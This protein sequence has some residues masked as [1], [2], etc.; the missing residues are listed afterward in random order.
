MLS[1]M[2]VHAVRDASAAMAAL[3]DFAAD[4][5]LTDVRMPGTSGVELLKI[6]TR[7]RADLSIVLLTG[8]GDVPMAVETLKAGAFDFLTKPH[9]PERLVTV[10]RNAAEQSRLKSRIRHLE[11]DCNHVSS[12]E[13]ALIGNAPEMERLRSNILDLA[14]LPVDVLLLGET[15]TGKE[16]AARA[17]HDFGCRR[18]KP[19]VAINCAAVPAEIFESELFGHEAGAFTGARGIRVGKFEYANGGTVLLDEIE[20]M[21]LTAQAKVLRVL[22]ERAVE[23]IGSNRAIAFD[24]RLVTATK[25]DLRCEVAAGRFREDLFYRLAGVELAI[26]PLRNRGED[27]QLLFHWFAAAMAERIGRPLPRFEATTAEWLIAQA[28]PGNVRELKT[29]A[30]RFVLGFEHMMQSMSG[31]LGPSTNGLADRVARFERALI[32]EALREAK[33]SITV[34]ME[35]LQLPRRTLSEKMTRYGISKGDFEG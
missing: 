34:M 25:A 32:I 28:W 30:E 17:L 26:P 16:V 1:G 31:A 33:G 7:S 18:K 20:S 19:F 2:D 35:R 12:I 5:V 29:A 13:R 23:R 6:L 10:L 4:V 11:S 21:P 9:D 14:N 3:E 27:I 15:G 24:I 22:Q 8:H